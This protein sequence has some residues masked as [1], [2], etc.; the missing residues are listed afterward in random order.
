MKVGFTINLGTSKEEG[1]TKFEFLRVDSSES[2]DG[3]AALKELYNFLK[4]FDHYDIKRFVSSFYG[5]R[6]KPEVQAEKEEEKKPR[7]KVR[8]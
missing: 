2:E 6:I 3:M 7:K 5:S 8:D 4:Q 1:T